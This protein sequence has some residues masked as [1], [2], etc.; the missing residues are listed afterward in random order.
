MECTKISE[1]FDILTWIPNIQ[2]AAECFVNKQL[3][4]KINIDQATPLSNI[5]VGQ[6]N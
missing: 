1:Q 6:K 3:I 2:P 4:A 5:T